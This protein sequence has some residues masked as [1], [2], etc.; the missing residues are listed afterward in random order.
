MKTYYI[1]TSSLNFNN[2]FS[3]ES[4]SP[5]GFYSQRKFGYSNWV[6]IPENPIEGAVLLYDTFKHFSRPA[7]N[8]EDH[9]MVIEIQID[10]D[11]PKLQD[12]IFNST[13]T[14]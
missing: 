8:L 11:F 10:E 1:P 2:I 9:P 14:L 6:Q 7:S 5:M 3:S 13:H 4:I 12:G